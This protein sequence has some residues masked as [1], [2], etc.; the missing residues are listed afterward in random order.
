MRFQR[1]HRFALKRDV[2]LD[3]AAATRNDEPVLIDHV[4]I[5]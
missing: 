2:A 1:A 4:R 5:P 3:Q